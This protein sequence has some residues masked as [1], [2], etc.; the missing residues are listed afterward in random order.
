MTFARANPLGWAPFELLLSTQMNVIDS[1]MPFALDG[2]AGGVYTLTGGIELDAS[3]MTPGTPI[4]SLISN[5]SDASLSIQNSVGSTNAVLI[6]HSGSAPAVEIDVEVNVG[7]LDLQGDPLTLPG[8]RPATMAVIVG[9]ENDDV[10]VNS[11]AGTG[12]EVSGGEQSGGTSA[13]GIGVSAVGG[14]TNAASGAN[15]GGTALLGVGGAATAGAEPGAGLIAGGGAGSGGGDGGVG[16]FALGGDGADGGIGLTAVGGDGATGGVGLSV[17]GGSVG[18]TGL[19]VNAGPGGGTAIGATI[20]GQGSGTGLIAQGGSTSGKGIV[21]TGFSSS[22]G[23]EANAGPSDGANAI[24][25]RNTSDLA[26]SAG[27]AVFAIANDGAS[28]IRLQAGGGATKGAHI[29]FDDFLAVPN[30]LI[31]GMVWRFNNATAAT[32]GTAVRSSLKVRIGG[33]TFV[34]LV[35]PE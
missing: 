1:Q 3:L 15:F 20:D 2:A 35:E 24:I 22:A 33:S 14:A 4:L 30:T 10:A 29:L 12:L 26:G 17:V 18:G 28:A 32:T 27:A 5:A 23:L 8:V 6:S 19:V 31:N 9:F 21:A 16:A 13:G 25:A 34:V 11:T 7:A